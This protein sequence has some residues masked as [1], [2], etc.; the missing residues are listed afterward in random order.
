MNLQSGATT[1]SM[2]TLSI[3]TSQKWFTIIMVVLC[4]VSFMPNVVFTECRGALKV[5]FDEY[6]ILAQCY[7]LL[8]VVIY[9]SS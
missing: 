7:K 4:R 3:T 1:L 8:T 6:V 9:G 5:H 2:T